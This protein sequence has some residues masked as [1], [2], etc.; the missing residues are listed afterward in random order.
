MTAYVQAP[1]PMAVAAAYRGPPVAEVTQPPIGACVNLTHAGKGLVGV[2]YRSKFLHDRRKT[3]RPNLT[4][5]R[6]RRSIFAVMHHT[7]PYR[8]H[9]RLCP[10]KRA[11]M[12]RRQF[13]TLLGGAAAWPLAA[14]AQ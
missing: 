7:P 8:R 13:I 2:R 3:W 1:R 6:H 14:C 4:P 9:G 11:L 12:R 5:S 10:G